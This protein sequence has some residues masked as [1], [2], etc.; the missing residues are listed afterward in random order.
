MAIVPPKTLFINQDSQTIILLH[1]YTGSPNDFRAVMRRLKQ[2]QFSVYA[3]LFSGHGTNNPLDILNK[4]SVTAWWNDTQKAIEFV[5][6]Q[7]KKVTAIFG[8]SLGSIF[9]LKALETYPQI[10]GG[11][12]L[13][14]PL[15]SQDFTNVR[16]GFFEY[17]RK[18]D[19]LQQ[20]SI[21][22]QA[23]HQRTIERLLGPALD[24]IS[25]AT[26]EVGQQLAKIKQPVFIGHGTKD[27][28]VNYQA[29]QQLQSHLTTE[30]D[31]HL[32]QDAGHVIT[33]NSARPQLEKDLLKFLEQLK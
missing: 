31:F 23:Q 15:F 6:Q 10:K 24:S 33:V 14:S 21:A 13:G 30:T 19:Q 11:G 28:M 9:A 27:E 25:Q 8:L 7:N 29:A 26:L 20:I 32:Y 4:G 17:A 2:A 3:P 1:S 5:Q 22:Q 12:V 16:A 18:I